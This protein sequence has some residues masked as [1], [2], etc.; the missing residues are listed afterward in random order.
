MCVSGFGGGSVGGGRHPR[1]LDATTESPVNSS[2]TST[3]VQV[4]FAEKIPK[5]ELRL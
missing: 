3:R 2:K 5:K 1:T 4:F